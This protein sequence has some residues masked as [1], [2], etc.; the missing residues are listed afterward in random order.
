MTAVGL[1]ATLLCKQ[2]REGIAEL[3]KTARDDACVGARSVDLYSA[4]AI[5]EAIIELL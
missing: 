2:V 4:R 5:E 3:V 1:S